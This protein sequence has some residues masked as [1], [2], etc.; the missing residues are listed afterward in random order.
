MADEKNM[1]QTAHF[2][3]ITLRNRKEQLAH[4]AEEIEKL[5]QGV[6]KSEPS[7]RI[8]TVFDDEAER[9]L[10]MPW[11]EEQD[12]HFYNSDVCGNILA[13]GQ[14]KHVINALGKAVAEART[15]YADAVIMRDEL[16]S[17]K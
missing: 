15:R 8:S 1:L 9:I 5:R 10:A 11:P 4:L 3:V 7:P 14:A 6:S 17:C 12:R 2:C 16:R 13:Q